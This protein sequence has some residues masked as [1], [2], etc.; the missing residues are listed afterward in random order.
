MLVMTVRKMES[1]QSLINC[2]S[3]E[4][5]DCPVCKGEYPDILSDRVSGKVGE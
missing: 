2:G 1:G 5:K 4:D 3:G